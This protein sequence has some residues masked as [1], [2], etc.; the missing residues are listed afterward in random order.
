[1]IIFFSG[2][3]NTKYCATKLAAI[4]GD[5]VRQVTVADLTEPAS[6]VIKTDEKRVVWMFPTYS[7]GVPKQ[8]LQ[9]MKHAKFA[10]P[11]DALHWM[12]TTC[13]DDI[14]KTAAQWRRALHR[15]DCVT[16]SA[17]SV[18]MPNTYT[19]MKGFDVDAPELEKSKIEAALPRL[20]RIAEV[21]AHGE[22]VADD[23]VEGSFAWLKTAVVYPLFNMFCMS[24]R[25][26]YA[27]DDC[28]GCGLC[29]KA[30]PMENIVPGQGNAPLWHDNCMLCTRCYHICPCHAVQYGK[31]T[32]G[33]G[34][35]RCFVKT[36]N[37]K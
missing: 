23:V 37:D 14:G 17:F 36:L 15:R 4:L 25:R 16:A 30:C 3:G 1:M 22:P 12:V 13:G 31:T 10:V 9:L 28:T 33:K 2:T 32:A 6:A 21:V 11:A 20:Q 7:W 26:F 18:Q 19:F 34:Q 35:A 29:R 24:P 27:N 8:I 5:D